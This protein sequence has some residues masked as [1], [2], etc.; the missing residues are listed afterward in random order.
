MSSAKVKKIKIA[1]DTKC[2][3]CG[4]TGCLKIVLK[5][6]DFVKKEC[7]RCGRVIYEY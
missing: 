3:Y 7:V 5:Y 4:K 2:P 6:R 1:V